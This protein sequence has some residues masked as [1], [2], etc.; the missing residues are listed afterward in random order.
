VD[1]KEGSTS[2]GL[3][4]YADSWDG[5]AEAFHFEDG[6]DRVRLALDDTG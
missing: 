3:F 2:Q 6:S 5:Y 1:I 4:A